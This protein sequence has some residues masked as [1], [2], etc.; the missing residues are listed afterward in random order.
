METIHYYEI[1]QSD[2]MDVL[3]GMFGYKGFRVTQNSNHNVEIHVVES[4]WRYGKDIRQIIVGGYR[5]KKMTIA[6]APPPMVA[7][8]PPGYNVDYYDPSVI[9]EK[10]DIIENASKMSQEPIKKHQTRNLKK[11]LLT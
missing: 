3:E 11:L 9:R 10:L 8:G 4:A 7:F 6:L 2:L 1:A 5:G